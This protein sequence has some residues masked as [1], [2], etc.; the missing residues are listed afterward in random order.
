MCMCLHIWCEEGAVRDGLGC[1]ERNPETEPG[2]WLRSHSQQSKQGAEGKVNGKVFKPEICPG[3]LWFW[4]R[5]VSVHLGT[6]ISGLI[7]LF[8]FFLQS[9]YLLVVYNCWILADFSKWPWLRC[10]NLFLLSQAPGGSAASCGASTCS[11]L[12]GLEVKCGVGGPVPRRN[13]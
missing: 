6:K 5:Q 2:A 11:F 12:G 10:Q 8:F 3:L 7:F 13:S 9:V 1:W 4:L